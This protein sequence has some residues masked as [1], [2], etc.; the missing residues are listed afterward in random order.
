MTSNRPYRRAMSRA[1]AREE[2]RLGLGT[3]F[4]ASAGQAL[5]DLTA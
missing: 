1:E 5:L 2:I 3:Q 4:C